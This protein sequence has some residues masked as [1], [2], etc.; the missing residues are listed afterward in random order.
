GDREKLCS[1]LP[2]H[3]GFVLQFQVN[4]VDQR[5]RLQSV[6]SPFVRH[7][8]MCHPPQLLVNNWHQLVERLA[9][10][11]SPL[12]KELCDLFWERL[13]HGGDH[14]TNATRN[15]TP[16]RRAQSQVSSYIK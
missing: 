15:T 7:L 6:A 12:A 16:A 1:A 5:G 2:P 11:R 4:F 8:A 14:D 10:T 9:I 3:L 13:R